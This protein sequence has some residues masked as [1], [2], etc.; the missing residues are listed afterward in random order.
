MHDFNDKLDEG[1][2]Y[3]SI[4][5]KFF[6]DRGDVSI[7]PAKVDNE[8]EEGFD[9]YFVHSTEKPPFRIE[10]KSDT[11]ATGTG[12]A[13]IETVSDDVLCKPGWVNKSRAD[14]VAYWPVGTGKIILVSPSILRQCLKHWKKEY[15]TASAKNKSWKTHGL[16]VP[17]HIVE[18]VAKKTYLINE[19]RYIGS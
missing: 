15:S 2:Y 14:Y 18:K 17:L 11:V 16:L 8:I 6:L 19:D 12:N 1:K 7:L 4:L 9:R 13:F 3:E 10:Y 5:D